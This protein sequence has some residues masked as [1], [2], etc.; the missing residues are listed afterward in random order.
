MCTCAVDLNELVVVESSSL[1]RPASPG[2]Q[3]WLI[4]VLH[5]PLEQFFSE[6][7]LRSFGRRGLFLP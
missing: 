3:F 4:C 6:A 2:R 7:T 1:R 5:S